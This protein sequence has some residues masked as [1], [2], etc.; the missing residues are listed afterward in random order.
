MCVGCEKKGNLAGLRWIGLFSD[1]KITLR[2]SAFDTLC[3]TLEQQM[4][5]DPGE[6][7]M[8]MLQLKFEI[9]SKDGSTETRTSNL[10][11][12]GGPNGYSNMAK[13]IGISC[14]TAVLDGTILE[15]GILAPLTL[16]SIIL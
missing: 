1:E 8:V 13:L 7:D 14:A 2:G 4:Q 9:K 12:Y 3:A 5:Y 15:K 10:C 6:R 11:G 16:K